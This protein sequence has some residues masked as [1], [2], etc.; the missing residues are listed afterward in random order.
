MCLDWSPARSAW[1]MIVSCTQRM[2]HDSSRIRRESPPGVSAGSIRREYPPGVSTSSGDYT[3]VP[4][5]QYKAKLMFLMK[6]DLIRTTSDVLNGLTIRFRTT[7]DVLNGLTIRF[8]TTSDVL[9]GLTI[10]FW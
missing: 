8:R 9:N 10:R 1:V 7:S 2:G 4:Q 6:N 3:A 5:V